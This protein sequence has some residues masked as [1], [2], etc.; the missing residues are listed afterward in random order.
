MRGRKTNAEI[1]GL[2][3]ELAS[4]RSADVSVSQIAA[5]AGISRQTIYLHFGSRGGLLVELVRWADRHFEITENFAA[6][7]ASAPNLL[8]NKLVDVSIFDDPQ[9]LAAAALPAPQRPF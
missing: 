7:P 4:E 1:L 6:A 2:A 3:W 8:H 5:D 9:P